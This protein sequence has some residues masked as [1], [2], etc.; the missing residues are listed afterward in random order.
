MILVNSILSVYRTMH[1]G[2]AIGGHHCRP[3]W[4]DH[5]LGRKYG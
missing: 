1:D 5:P 4:N 2:C 3:V